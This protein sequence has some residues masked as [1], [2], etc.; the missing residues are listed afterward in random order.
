MQT[1]TL[2][3]KTIL[4]I[5]QKDRNW[6]KGKKQILVRDVGKVKSAAQGPGVA[7]QVQKK[8]EIRARR[9]HHSVP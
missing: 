3:A 1:Q 9:W 8:R 7:A 4:I 2:E 6:G 5:Q